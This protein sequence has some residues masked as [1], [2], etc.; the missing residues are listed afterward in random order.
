MID[1]V[2]PMKQVPKVTP[3]LAAITVPIALFAALVAWGFSSPVGSSP[4][5]D[6]H[7]ASIWCGAG[8]REGLCEKG[9]KP[10]E[11]RV[12][13]TLLEYSGCYAFKPTASADCAQKPS[14]VLVNTS[15]GNFNASYP[16]LFYGALSIF[17]SADVASSILLMRAANALL[18]TSV[19]T[20][21]FFALRP[22]SRG[23]L[24]WSG[25]ATIV[26][27]GMFLIP[28]V[29]PSSWAVM[30][31]MGLWI[32]LTALWR[33]RARNRL[34]L[35]GSLAVAM[36]LAA[37][38]ARSDAA[39]YSATAAVIAVVLSLPTKWKNRRNLVLL[40]AS[41]GAVIV[42][43]AFFSSSGQSSVLSLNTTPDVQRNLPDTIAL[44]LANLVLL[45]ELWA[46]A[47]GTSGLG[48]LDTK[49]PGSVWVPTLLVFA[50]LLFWGLKVMTKRKA[51]SLILL[52]LGLIAVPLY[53]LVKDNV[54]V[55]AGV[56]PRYVLPLIIIFIGVALFGFASDNLGLSRLQG[57]I[58]GVL[59]VVAN[60][61]ALHTNIRRYV[62]GIDRQGANLDSQAEWW[63]QGTLSP[64]GT[65]TVGVLAF[66]IAM[67]GLVAY[68]ARQDRI[69]LEDLPIRDSVPR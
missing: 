1:G 26:P 68:M 3:V 64:M 42:A 20:A 31:A 62:T 28:S 58:V 60:T 54:M 17:A 56:Q 32:A 29:N 47:L 9:D 53:V 44:A 10:D 50:G 13:A 66:A 61:V 15:R 23:P 8:L 48:W 5:D 52:L 65:W 49:L 43:A 36:L 6:Y 2:H 16:P 39:A 33:E 30:S 34:I 12:P 14:S 69:L 45:P 57:V 24:L 21:L 4:D 40:A 51:V 18:F 22:G 27:L 41:V 35:L 11:R 37:S 46:G 59:L 7:M 67:A 63:W 19:W 38:G 55:G 25:L